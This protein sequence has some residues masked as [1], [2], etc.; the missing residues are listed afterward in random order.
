M[1]IGFNR[2]LTN[3][4]KGDKHIGVGIGD[5]ILDLSVVTEFYPPDLEVNLINQLIRDEIY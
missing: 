1:S 4:F 3:Y 5:T 2:I